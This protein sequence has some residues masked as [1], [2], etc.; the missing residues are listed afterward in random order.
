M[1]LEVAGDS[2]DGDFASIS[3]KKQGIYRFRNRKYAVRRENMVADVKTTWN[4][5]PARIARVLYN[6]G[7]L[8][9]VCRL[10]QC[11]LR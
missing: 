8:G 7:P 10:F 5:A 3:G 2:I 11:Q 6:F 1:L 9:F 4:A